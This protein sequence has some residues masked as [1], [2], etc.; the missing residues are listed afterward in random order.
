[1]KFYLRGASTGRSAI[2]IYFI[3]IPAFVSTL[4]WQNI[5]E[6]GCVENEQKYDNINE[7]NYIEIDEVNGLSSTFF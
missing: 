7:S 1:M 4:Y 3:I 6:T 5:L 2:G